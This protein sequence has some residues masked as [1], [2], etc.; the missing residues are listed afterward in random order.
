[1]PL[2]ELSVTPLASS[3]CDNLTC[4]RWTITMDKGGEKL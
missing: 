2:D 1:M 3:V 4:G